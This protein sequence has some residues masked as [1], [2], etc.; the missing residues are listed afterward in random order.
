M[1]NLYH[2]VHVSSSPTI[3]RRVGP[4]LFLHPANTV[5]GR[6]Y[7]LGQ[8]EASCALYRGTETVELLRDPPLVTQHGPETSCSFLPWPFLSTPP[9]PQHRALIASIAGSLERRNKMRFSPCSSSRKPTVCR[10][11]I[12]K[13]CVLY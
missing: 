1:H 10:T 13:C 12:H 11:R 3:L 6:N 8:F 5:R 7:P 2:S 4:S 9:H